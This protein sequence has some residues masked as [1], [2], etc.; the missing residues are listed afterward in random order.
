MKATV[1]VPSD[2]IVY[3]H[4]VS[5]CGL[6]PKSAMV[7]NDGVRGERL[8]VYYEGNTVNASNLHRYAERV[9][10]AVGRWESNYP[11]SAVI[12]LPREF[13]MKVGEWDGE[14]IHLA[15]PNARQLAWWL[16][17]DMLDPR[18]LVYR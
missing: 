11:T 7:A 8:T 18:E 10:S 9:A 17:T 1:Y 15:L 6:A 3:D 13:L 14:R 2:G 5:T 4:L 12:V 16:D